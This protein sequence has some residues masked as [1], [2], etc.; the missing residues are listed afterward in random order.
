MT[1][2][3]PPCSILLLAGGRGQRVGGRDKGLLDW[4][5]RPL[6]AHLHALARPFSDDLIISC[7]RNPDRYARYADQLVSDATTDFPGPLAGILAGLAQ[8]RHEQVLVLPCDA[9]SLD[10]ELLHNLLVTATKAAQ[11]P[12]MIRQGEQ[13][14][15]L[16]CV[17]PKSL[18][19]PLLE[20]WNRG[21]RSPLRALLA[22]GAQAY[23]C[24]PDDPRL[25]NLN[26]PEL[27]KGT[28]TK[29]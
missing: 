1:R 25:T 13:W 29:D 23:P 24:A 5:G 11:Q 7:N 8:A 26:T 27:L 18:R 21:E 22:L 16:F 15:P 6:I 19:E 12:L 28:P 17:L 3:A 14:Q 20:C 9:P 10:A 4:H 2:D